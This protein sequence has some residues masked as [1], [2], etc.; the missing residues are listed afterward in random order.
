MGSL[1]ECVAICQLN[2][3][4]TE[5]NGYE[6]RSFRDV[7]FATIVL[8]LDAIMHSHLVPKDRSSDAVEAF[9]IHGDT[10]LRQ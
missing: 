6:Q 10:L 3:C 9:E 7:M 8:E 4:L 1:P 5:S 2:I